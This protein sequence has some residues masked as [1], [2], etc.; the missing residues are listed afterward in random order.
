MTEGPDIRETAGA[1]PSFD[2]AIAILDTLRHIQ[3]RGAALAAS[4]KTIGLAV[5]T[6]HAGRV[7]AFAAVAMPVD[8]IG[9]RPPRR[10][11]R[12]G[13]IRG[14][15]GLGRLAI[16]EPAAAPATAAT[17]ALRS[18]TGDGAPSRPLARPPASTRHHQRSSDG[19]RPRARP[20][21]SRA[22]AVCGPT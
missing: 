1:G 3:P 12:S 16:A 6:R 4:G 22:Q 17:E 11:S 20:T 9:R 19:H 18:P 14:T 10:A 8:P 13:T 7:A 2:D 15:L 21:G 5:T